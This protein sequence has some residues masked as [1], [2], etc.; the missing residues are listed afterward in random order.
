MIDQYCNECKQIQENST[1]S[2][3]AHHIMAKRLG[4][5]YTFFQLIPAIASALVGGLVVGQVVPPWVGIVSLVA[6]IVTAIGTVKNPQQEYYSHLNAAKAFT[7]LKHD[8][9]ALHEIFAPNT[10][11]AEMAIRVKTLHDRYNEVIRVVPPTEDWAFDKARVRIKAGVHECDGK[12][13]A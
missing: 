12:P 3:E 13:K 8:A 10:P 1:Y 11:D 6:A 2:A 4:S 5:W 9:R 7:V